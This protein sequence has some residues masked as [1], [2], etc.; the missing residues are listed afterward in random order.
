MYVRPAISKLRKNSNRSYRL[1]PSLQSFTYET[2][3]TRSVFIHHLTREQEEVAGG[4]ENWA[5]L[6]WEAG[7][8]KMNQLCWKEGEGCS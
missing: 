5:L 6:E 2:R 3:N 4:L 8:E 7:K 1:F